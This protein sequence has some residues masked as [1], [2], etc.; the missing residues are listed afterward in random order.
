M[1]RARRQAE[2]PGGQQT[3]PGMSSR[4]KNTPPEKENRPSLKPTAGATSS[5]KRKR[6]QHRK[7]DAQEP[8]ETIMVQ[9]ND[10]IEALGRDQSAPLFGT[11]RSE[12]INGRVKKKQRAG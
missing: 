5:Q 10:S 3:C 6:G 2:N 9:L 8:F 1:P 12:R 4:Q 11:R 7:S